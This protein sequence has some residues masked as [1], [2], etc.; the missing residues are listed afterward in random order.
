MDIKE[1]NEAIGRALNEISDA[2][3]NA[4]AD[5]RKD[6]FDKKN[7]KEAWTD[8]G[9][10]EQAVLDSIEEK[11]DEFF[12]N[13]TINHYIDSYTGKSFGKVY[14]PYSDINLSSEQLEILDEKINTEY[15]I[16]INDKR[17]N[18]G[19]PY[20]YFNDKAKRIEVGDFADKV[21]KS[22]FVKNVVTVIKDIYDLIKQQEI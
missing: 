15:F 1:L 8:T 17:F 21:K 11:I 3:V 5:K 7:M 13:A 14:I 22:S 10:K 4:V 9:D 18:E 16:S 2:P 12:P 19:Q 20:A 6:A